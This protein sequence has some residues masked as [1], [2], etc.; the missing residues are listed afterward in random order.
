MEAWSEWLNLLLRW[1]HVF[2]AI[3]WIGSTW[4]FTWLDRQM[5]L[6]PAGVWM[7]HSGG[8]YRVEKL[9]D[10]KVDPRALHWFRFE[11]LF[12]WLSGLALMVVVVY[13]GGLMEDS[14]VSPGWAIAC[15]IGV[16]VI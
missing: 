10:P 5:R 3:L 8:F 2:A 11:A 13:A 1:F 14:A 16:L 6:S 7:L 12:T 4:Y 15:G 9:A